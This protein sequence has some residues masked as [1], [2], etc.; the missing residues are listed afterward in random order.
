MLIIVAQG[1]AMVVYALQGA[2]RDPDFNPNVARPAYLKLHPKILIDEAHNNAYTSGGRYKPFADLITSDGYAV[3]RNTRRFSRE[4]LTAYKVLV[5]VNA[6]G[7]PGQP[8]I[9][10]FAEDELDAVSDWVSKGGG[11]LVITDH[12]PYSVAAAALSKRF[13]VDITQGYT[14]DP[15]RYNKESEDQT[16]LVFTRADGLLTEHPI[17][18]GATRRSKSKESS[19]LRVPR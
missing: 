18:G 3:V 11:L 5:I 10:P 9:S 4:T 1:V 15:L 7:P 12:P 6:Q 14:I 17:R 13:E 8:G 16:E 19:P 2:Q